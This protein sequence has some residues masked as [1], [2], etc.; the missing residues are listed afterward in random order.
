MRNVRNQPKITQT[1]IPWWDSSS[2]C[3]QS[4]EALHLCCSLARWEVGG[5]R[6]RYT[7]GWETLSAYLLP[8]QPSSGTSLQSIRDNPA[9]VGKDKT[10]VSEERLLSMC[11]SIF[12]SF[13]S[14]L[15]CPS[16]I[17]DFCLQHFATGQIMFW[18]CVLLIAS[19]C[20]LFI[21]ESIYFSVKKTIEK[22]KWKKKYLQTYLW[23]SFPALC[24]WVQW[25]LINWCSR[26]DLK[27]KC[28]ANWISPI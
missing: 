25:G 21:N 23:L 13:I 2:G 16:E 17:S 11:H 14:S 7:G 27:I 6:S 18:K 12:Y 8:W 9:F 19:Q 4:P 20:S 1:R 26:N 5:N 22:K 15:Q 28:T 10:E 24:S 3:M